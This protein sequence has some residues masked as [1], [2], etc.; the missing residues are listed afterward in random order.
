VR[1]CSR[2]SVEFLV[3]N[4]GHGSTTTLG[5]FNGVQISMSG[6]RN[7]RIEPET[8]AAWF[9][10]GVYSAQVNQYL[11]EQGY[12]ATT[13]AADCVGLA[14]A[15]LGGGHGRLEG[16]Y[17]MVSDNFRQFNVV[18][19]DG[20]AI[21][22]NST[23][24]ADL[25]W[26]MRGAGHN[27]GIVTSFEM[28]IHPRG[29]ETWHYKNYCWRGDK[30]ETIFNTINK[31]HGNGTTPV[32][33]AVN[34]GSFFMNTSISTT[35]PVIFWIFV[36]RGS[37]RDAAPYLDPFDAIDPVYVE[38]GNVP[39]PQ[40][41][42]AQKVGLDDITCQDNVVRIVTTSG[43]QV[44][45]VTTERQIWAGFTQRVHDQPTLA[46][47]AVIIHEGYATKAVEDQDPNCSAYP[48]RSD[49]HLTQ[50]QGNLAVGSGLENEMWQWADEVRG[51]WNAGQPGR[52]PSAYV[53]YANGREGVLEWY[54]HEE[55]RIA[56]LRGL[57]SKYDPGNR[58]RYY[59]P[60]V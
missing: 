36:Y 37:E 42:H 50:F 34:Y 26:A 33:M 18:L 59:N 5:S 15:G 43:L 25:F 9:Q 58:F 29:P 10:G 7:I 55:W 27:F 12:V 4:R 1:Y 53:N 8:S 52:L 57:K 11:W 2:V 48:F 51:A 19:G 20:S 13:G 6:L 56:R 3:Y 32:D 60:I 49:R 21:R 39:Y 22:V 28:N 45:N 23:S 38:S 17:G 14:G 44:W 24:H 41:A 47:G 54:G 40:V 46:A 16:L 35:E 30:L 31:L